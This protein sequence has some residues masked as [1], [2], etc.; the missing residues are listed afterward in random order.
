[1]WCV[2]DPPI[3]G[4][5]ATITVWPG[6]VDES[7]MIALSS[8]RRL[9]APSHRLFTLQ[10]A[11]SIWTTEDGTDSAQAVTQI[12]EKSWSSHDVGSNELLS[13]APLNV[14]RLNWKRSRCSTPQMKKPWNLGST[15]PER[16]AD[17]TAS[18][19]FSV[20]SRTLTVDIE[21]TGHHPR[22]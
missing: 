6:L 5:E 22:E 9:L 10:T 15:T 19:E 14:S 17:A 4:V 3:H 2:L 20:L 11:T 13:L 18:S 21:L 7:T 12:G 8:R 1:M 16:F